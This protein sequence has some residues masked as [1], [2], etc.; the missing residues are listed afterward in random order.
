MSDLREQLKNTGKARP[1]WIAGPCV[2]ESRTVLAEV[3]HR[4]A[5]LSQRH[6]VPFIF[7][8]SF[9]KANRTAFTSARGPGLE[10]GLKDLA[11][12]KAE[13]DLPILTDV[14]ETSQVDRVAEVVDVLQ[15]PAFLCRQTDLIEAA[16]RTGRWVNV[17][18]G[19]FLSPSGVG[20]LVKK[21]ENFGANGFWITERGVSFGYQRLVVDFSVFPEM[22][23]LK[24]PLVMDITHSVQLMSGDGSASG[25][26]REAI[27]Y[28][29]RAA[30]AVG[31]LGFFAE[32]HPDP[33]KSLSDA[34][35]AWPLAELPSLV[36]SV[37]KIAESAHEF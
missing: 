7:K 18:K 1:F 11:W 15:I 8:A 21:L 22:E 25:G 27:P 20:A 33:A 16:S 31:V 34:A 4:V 30:A 24:A 29:A 2:I 23:R 12:V 6:G 32:T 26:I 13:F 37:Q 14:H 5:E 19:Q 10:D 3:A 17:K 28:L 9:D 35:N 36:A